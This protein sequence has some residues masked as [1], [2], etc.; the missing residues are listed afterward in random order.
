MADKR[1]YYEVLGLQKGANDVEIKKAYRKLAKQHHPDLN[2]NDKKS[3]AAFKEVNEAYEVLSDN[4]KRQRYDQFGQAGV[5]PSYGAGGTTGG[6][7]GYSGY[8]GGFEGV[9]IGDMFGDIFSGMFGGGFSQ[10]RTNAPVRGDNL[11][12]RITVTFDEAVFGCKKQIKYSRKETCPE[13]S[14]SG[15]AKGTSPETCSAC[16]GNGQ[17]K[18]MQHTPFGSFSSVTTCSVCGGTG[19]VV[20]TPCQ[21]CRGSGRTVKEHSIDVSIPAGIDNGQTISLSG[22]GGHGTRGGGAGD[23]YITVTVKPHNIFERRGSDIYCDIPL[24]YTQAALGC[25]LEIPTVDKKSERISVPEGTQTNSVFHIRNKGVPYINGRGR[26][27]QHVRIVIEVPKHL[28]QRQKDILR[29]FDV[30]SGN[31]N[32]E[33]RKTFVDKVRETLGF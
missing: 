15:A 2:Q 13:C 3:E 23:L 4:D 29:E 25:E 19:K 6:A 27:D 18:R 8:G 10:R 30:I 24:T 11:E 1:D 28:S 32:Y 20:K 33:K 21:T 17:V 5:D 7:G 9:D 26:G 14:G 12:V 22:Q 16:R 31:K